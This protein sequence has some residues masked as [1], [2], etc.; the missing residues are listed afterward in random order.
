MDRKMDLNPCRNSPTKELDALQVTYS[1]KR[2]LDFFDDDSSKSDEEGQEN[3]SYF[4]G[5]TKN[6]SVTATQVVPTAKTKNKQ[7]MMQSPL[8][9]VSPNAGI[10]CGMLTLP[11]KY[12]KMPPSP[13]SRLAHA[14]AAS[15]CDEGKL[16]TINVLQ[17]ACTKCC[18]PVGNMNERASY[19]VAIVWKGVH[20]HGPY[21][22]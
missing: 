17:L 6:C 18:I 5:R 16:S 2:R 7:A 3:T 4:G 21:H 1:Q 19:G 15:C 22:S 13:M 9:C 12:P 8:T 11:M 20:S 10:N 14:A